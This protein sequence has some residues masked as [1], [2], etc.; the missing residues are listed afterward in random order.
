MVPGGLSRHTAP[1][2]APAHLMWG[3][4][5]LGWYY[6]RQCILI[7]ALA[8]KLSGEGLELEPALSLSRWKAISLL[9]L[10]SPLMQPNCLLLWQCR[11]RD[12]GRVRQ[13]GLQDC[14][15][16]G[17]EVELPLWTG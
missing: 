7:A 3:T 9:P 16:F 17:Q 13:V 15:E 11:R 1:S 2:S 12:S 6:S 4:K 10:C 5:Q 8:I 14:T